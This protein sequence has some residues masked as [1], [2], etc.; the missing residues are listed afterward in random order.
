MPLSGEALNLIS[1][2][3]DGLECCTTCKVSSNTERGFNLPGQKAV[4]AVL[5]DLIAILFPGC[6]GYCALS[7]KDMGKTLRDRMTETMNVLREQ[8]RSAFE[9]QCTLEECDDCDKC[10]EKA[11]EVI[12]NMLKEMPGTQE[13]LQDDIVAAYEGDPAAGSTMEVVMSYP[14]LH[15]VTVQRIAHLLHRNKVPL[16]PRIMSYKSSRN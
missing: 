6:H 1:E 13:M 5:E 12:T 9:Y 11:D 14:G 2:I 8:I 4:H 3:V 16:I 7:E 10:G 15:A